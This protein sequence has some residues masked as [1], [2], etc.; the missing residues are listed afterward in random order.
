MAIITSAQSG[1]WSATTTWE[2]GSVP[3]NNDAVVIATGHTIVFDVDQSGFANGLT[4]LSGAG[5]LSF[6]KDTRTYLKMAAN[7]TLTGDFYVGTETNPI[8]PTSDNNPVMANIC[9]NGAFQITSSP[10]N[11]ELWGEERQGYDTVITGGGSGDST[12]TLKDG[13]N[14][15]E[16]DVVYIS[17]LTQ[18]INATVHTVQSY[19]TLTKVVTFT[20]T[21]GRTVEA[22]RGVTLD[23]RNIQCM[24]L[25]KTGTTGFTNTKNNGKATGVRFFNFGRAPLDARSGWIIRYCTGNNNT[26]GGISYW[27]SGHTI[28]SCIG[29]NNTSGGISHWGS[30]H[31]LNNCTGN[32]NTLGGISYYG[33]GHTITSCTGNNNTNGGISNYGSGHTINNCNSGTQGDSTGDLFASQSFIIRNSNLIINNIT[34]SAGN[35]QFH[36]VVSF[37]H[38]KTPGDYKAWMLG[39]VVDMIGGKLRF[40]PISSIYPVY[41]DYPILAPA[42]RTIKQLIGLTKSTPEIVTKLQFIDPAN[43]PLIDSTA[44]PLAES[45]EIVNNQIGIAYKSD[46]AKQI[47]LR[48]YCQNSTGNV[49]IDTTR[50]DQSLAKKI[51]SLN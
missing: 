49:I 13:L 29:N 31:T 44:L 3:A 12:I 1:N 30:G 48:I 51:T 10:A 27:G 36:Q 24:N 47:I 46:T 40:N 33:S 50:I 34:P 18:G 17:H 42:N 5:N 9:F 11:L 16:G 37:D 32:N 4:G 43:D 22:G 21:L 6:K 41:R 26:N 25:N 45:S 15:R 35:L 2:G 19:N 7:I 39:G 38:N 20:S 23:S 8:L 28:T 14:L